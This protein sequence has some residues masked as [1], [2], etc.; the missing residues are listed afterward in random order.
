MKAVDQE[1]VFQVETAACL[2]PA[3]KGPGAALSGYRDRTLPERLSAKRMSAIKKILSN[4]CWR[5][6]VLPEL[7]EDQISDLARASTAEQTLP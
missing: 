7:S 1:T 3:P 6:S 2:I 4:L 5:G